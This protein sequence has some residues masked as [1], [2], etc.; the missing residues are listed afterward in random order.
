MVQSWPSLD[1]S[2]PVDVNEPRLI[3][4]RPRPLARDSSGLAAAITQPAHPRPLFPV[5]S[6]LDYV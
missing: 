1:G 5:I 4:P 2:V 6:K 3:P